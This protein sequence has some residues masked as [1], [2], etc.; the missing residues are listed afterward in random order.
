MRDLDKFTN[1]ER[2]EMIRDLLA[3]DIFATGEVTQVEAYDLADYANYVYHKDGVN[4]TAGHSEYSYEISDMLA[5]GM[6]VKE[7]LDLDYNVI[8]DKIAERTN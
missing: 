1:H 3:Y 5:N 7:I 2:Q 6:S 8:I 4:L